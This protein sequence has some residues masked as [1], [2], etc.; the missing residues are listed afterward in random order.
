MEPFYPYSS[1]LS[2][3]AKIV[4][5]LVILGE[6]LQ[7]LKQMRINHQAENQQPRHKRYLEKGTKI[8]ETH[9]KI[10]KVHFQPP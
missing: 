2:I 3:P 4:M 5:L 7:W 6:I 10:E 1:D 8:D 9:T